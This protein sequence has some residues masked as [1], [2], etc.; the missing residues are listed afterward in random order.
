MELGTWS[1]WFEAV[2]ELLAVAVALFLPAFQ[3]RKQKRLTRRRVSRNIRS[4]TTALMHE[5]RKADQWQ[6]TYQ[7]LQT[8]L[9]LYAALLTDEQGEPII[10]IGEHL[11]TVLAQPM[12]DT[13]EITASLAELANCS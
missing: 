7:S 8:L 2:G 4:L 5:N 10:V 3:E 1:D 9:R 12:P 13:E 6:E 11:L